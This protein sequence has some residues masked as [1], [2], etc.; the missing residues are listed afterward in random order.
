MNA[1]NS[2]ASS[3]RP[4]FTLTLPNEF[5]T[6]NVTVAAVNTQGQVQSSVITVCPG[7]NSQQGA[8]YMVLAYSIC[9]IH[10]FEASNDS[11]LIMI[12]TP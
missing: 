2:S 12:N 5:L 8:Q 6:Y 3:P 10:E 7:Q 11:K 4:Y 1:G 9:C